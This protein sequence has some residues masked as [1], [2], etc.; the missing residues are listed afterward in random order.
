M[1][2]R[3]TVYLL[4]SDGD[5][6]RLGLAVSRKVGGAVVRNR[7]KRRLRESFRRRVRAT[8]PRVTDVVVRAEPMAARAPQQELE[9]ALAGAIQSWLA[10]GLRQRKPRPPAPSG[11]PA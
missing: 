8:L 9:T 5:R 6:S 2:F 3:S 7:V 11:A 4:A 10:S 1:L